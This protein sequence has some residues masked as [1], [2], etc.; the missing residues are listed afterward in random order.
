MSTTDTPSTAATP[1]EPQAAKPWG[2]EWL[3]ERL[4]ALSLLCMVAAVFTN[5]VLRYGFGTSIVFYE[6]LSRLMLIWMVCIGAVLASAKQQHLGFDMLTSRLKGIPAKL[7]W[8]LSQALIAGCLVLVIK[9]SWHQVQAG[10]QSMSTVMG[11]PLA[12]AAA[13][14]LVMG[15]GMLLVLI[16]ELWRGEPPKPNLVESGVE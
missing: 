11:Y 4:M 9:G 8:W 16:W 3:A 15:V 1:A 5:V 12:V 13:S 14:T 2:L 10:M 6:E 7:L